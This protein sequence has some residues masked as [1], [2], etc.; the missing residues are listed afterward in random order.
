[1]FDI[2]FWEMVIV[3]V[4]ALVVL[5]PERL[6]KV[7]RTL[8]LFVGRARATFYAVRSEV[9]RELELQEIRKTSQQLENEV[10]QSILPPQDHDKPKTTAGAM[11]NTAPLDKT[12]DKESAS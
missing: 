10:Q 11:G 4:V 12:A 6:P 2:G 3:C 8:G 9:E 1:M 5:G 7:A